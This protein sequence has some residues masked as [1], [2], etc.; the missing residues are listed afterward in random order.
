MFYMQCGQ[1][2]ERWLIGEAQTCTCER[3]GNWVGL[4]DEEI[5]QYAHEN[6]SC[7]DSFFNI[8]RGIYG[9]NEFARAI[10]AK[11]KDKNT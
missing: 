8:D 10:E 11:L 7:D 3:Q 5:K 1:C 6:L 2:G 9:W 4:T